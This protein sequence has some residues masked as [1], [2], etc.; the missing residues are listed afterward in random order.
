MTPLPT[1]AGLPSRQCPASG[2]GRPLE[3]RRRACSAKCRAAL[4]RENRAERQELRER[5]IRALLDHAERLE[6]QAAGL[7]AQARQRLR[8]FGP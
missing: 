8:A 3:G 4:S 5:E 7:R 6:A 2:C 1:G